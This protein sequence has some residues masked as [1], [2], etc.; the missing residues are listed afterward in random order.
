M[1]VT[2][3][4]VRASDGV[5]LA[6]HRLERGAELAGPTVLLVPGTFCQRTFWLGTR[7]EGFARRLAE[8]GFD[9]WAAELR[10]HGSSDRPAIWT[11]T[12]WIQRDAPALLEYV[13]R[14]AGS[15]RCFWVGH[16]SGGVVGTALLGEHPEL[17]DRLRG[18][19]L[20]ATP[21][22]GDAGALR[23]IGA[24]AAFVA[25]SL[26]PRASVPG[27]P[28]RLGP[29]HEPTALVREW[30]GWNLQG[31]WR[32]PE[33]GDYLSGLA[34]VDVPLLAVGGA[35]DAVLAPPRAVR[36]LARRFGS[37]D[38]TV[39]IAGRRTGFEIDFD[40]AGLVVSRSARTEVWPVVIEWLRE[41]GLAAG[42][43][44][45]THERTPG[46]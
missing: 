18:L 29:E 33:G 19:V 7:G 26:F 45:E 17:A 4:T 30:M 37:A 16:S 2:Q 10:G 15:D 27:R 40:H 28:I 20:L 3:H 46:G 14:T 21:G 5:R 44:R 6:V 35:G 13:L 36:D 22:P 32:R 39:V 9:C 43:G 38:A 12:D 41:R 23:R 11:M 31:V 34:S 8:A 25:A 42:H 1:N 24:G